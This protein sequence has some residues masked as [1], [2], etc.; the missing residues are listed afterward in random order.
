MRRRRRPA[1][2]NGNATLE[3]FQNQLREHSRHRQV[4]QHGRRLARRH[5]GH[6]GGRQFTAQL[7]SDS[8]TLS[9]ALSANLTAVGQSARRHERHRDAAQHAGQPVHGAGGLLATIN[10]GLQSSLSNLSRSNRRA[11]MR[12]SRPTRRRSPRSTTRWMR[13]LRR[14]R[15]PRPISRPS[16][17]RPSLEFQQLR[18]QQLE[19]RQPRHL[20]DQR[21]DAIRKVKPPSIAPCQPRP[22]AMRARRGSCRSCMS[23]CSRSSGIAQGLHG[24]HQRTTCR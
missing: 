15:R 2:W 24:A 22:G 4:R 13:P 19:Q 11:A 21:H 5:L 14:S 23:T 16:S 18:D 8:S 20:S 17:I 3:S 9:N 1:P 7:D 10:Q 12:S 6:H